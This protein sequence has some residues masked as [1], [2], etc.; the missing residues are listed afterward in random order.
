MQAKEERKTDFVYNILPQ[1]NSSDLTGISLLVREQNDW[2]KPRHFL[3]YRLNFPT[4][5]TNEV[6][7]VTRLSFDKDKLL[8]CNPT[9]KLLTEE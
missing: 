1:K 7:D 5:Y 6:L 4:N 3:I 8:L 9:S 2:H